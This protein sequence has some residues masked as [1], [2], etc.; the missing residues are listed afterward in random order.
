MKMITPLLACS[1]LTSAL[2]AEEFLVE[3]FDYPDGALTSGG[4][5]DTSSVQVI[6]GSVV[7]S[8]NGDGSG[9]ANAAK[10]SIPTQDLGSNPVYVIFWAEQLVNDPINGFAN[11]AL[12]NG[13]SVRLEIGTVL[14]NTEDTWN[15]EGYSD[16]NPSDTGIDASQGEL[17]R[18]VV[19]VTFGIFGDTAAMWVNPPSLSNLGTPDV[20]V[21][22]PE[23]NYS[24]NRIMIRS[25][26]DG[27]ARLLVDSI[28]VAD[29]TDGAPSADPSANTSAC[30]LSDGTCQTGDLG[31]C[32]AIGGEFQGDY[33]T[34]AFAACEAFGACCLDSTTCEIDNP[35]DCVTLGG[36]Y[37][38]DGESCDTTNCSPTGACCTPDGNCFP[39]TD[40]NCESGGG[41]FQGFGAS[42][43]DVTCVVDLACCIGELCVALNQAVC[44]ASGGNFVGGECNSSSCAAPCPTDLDG[45]GETGFTDIV[46]LLSAWGTPNG[47]VN[48]D[49]TTEFQDLI[50]LLSAF[51]DC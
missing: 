28:F 24:F 46:A 8:G 30:C 17:A 40:A 12:A 27:N 13:N 23:A 33:S 2:A 5:F 47:D 34:C 48:G 39:A 21:T 26:N 49:G 14:G 43:A 37:R 3:R 19:R 45:N 25:G 10:R 7:H 51:G 44:L 4:W 50:V 6:D 32:D 35:S 15:L 1:L 38:G 20:Q 11:I 41:T 31:F 9:Y 42:C 29:T 36:T 16:E 18:L 22:E